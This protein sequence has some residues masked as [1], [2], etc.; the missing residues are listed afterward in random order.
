MSGSE[1]TNLS[2][3]G[4]ATAK[5]QINQEYQDLCSLNIVEIPELCSQLLKCSARYSFIEV[6]AE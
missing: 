2:S 5:Q 3:H 4:Y 6:S 1:D